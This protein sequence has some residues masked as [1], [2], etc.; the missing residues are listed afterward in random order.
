MEITSK[1]KT[2]NLLAVVDELTHL[3][4]DTYVLY[5]KT[6]NFHWN[7]TGPDFHSLHLMFETQYNELAD[8]TDEIAE[9]IRA[10]NATAPASFSHFSKLSSLKEENGVP[11][12]Q[13]ML[14]QLT[15]DHE[16][17][18]NHLT[19]TITKAEQAQDEGTVDLLV[20]RLRAHQK[21]A[22]MLRSSIK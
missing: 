6:Q 1:M 15:H 22:W 19:A 10:L 5:L 9:R 17:I 7:V 2:S 8:A 13:D 16:T 18:A 14:K 20:Q 11:S 4:A 21:T 12:A 3:L